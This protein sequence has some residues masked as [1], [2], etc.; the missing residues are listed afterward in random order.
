MT[1][2]GD[3]I[4]S[5]LTCGRSHRLPLAGPQG[6]ASAGDFLLK[7]PAPAHQTTMG[8]LAGPGLAAQY[9]IAWNADVK[10]ALAAATAMT[11]TALNSNVSSATNIWG[12]AKVLNTS[13][14]YLD[15][16]LTVKLSFPNTAPASSKAVFVY[17]YG[18]LDDT[19]FTQP[20]TGSEGDFTVPDFTANPLPF[21]RIGSIPYN[22]ADDTIIGPPWLISSAFGGVLPP[23][24][25]VALINHTGATLDGSGN[26][27]M[28]RPLFVTV[29]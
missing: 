10:L 6:V 14:L 7:H 5:C 2:P 15:A 1:R 21:N 19:T 4:I 23:V 8:V 29:I 13:N 11:I 27:V 17:G 3:P 9:G 12:S 26:E 20:F 25:G 18:S 22:T 16:W 28:Y 24:W